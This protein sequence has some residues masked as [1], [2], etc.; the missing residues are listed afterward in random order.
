VPTFKCVIESLSVKYTM[1]SDQGVPL[2]A[3]CTVKLKEADTV[4]GQSESAG[5]GSTTGSP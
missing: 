4:T 3:T 2:R 5:T 1:F